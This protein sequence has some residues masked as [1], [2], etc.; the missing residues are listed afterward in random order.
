MNTI[1][2]TYWVALAVFA[3]A[4]N[5]EYQHGKFPLLH[6][7]AGRAG[8]ELCRIATRAEQT[9]AMARVLTG[10]EQQEFRVQ[11]FSMDEEFVARQEAEA[12]RAEHQADIERVMDLRRAD[13]DC[14]QQKLD[15]M[16]TALDRARLQKVRVLERTHLSMRDAANRRQIVVCPKTGARIAVD[17]SADLPDMDLEL[18]DVE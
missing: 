5:S 9:L 10:R 3:L 1:K 15:R 6:R 2:A 8:S 16:H 7:A 18:S 17:A 4:L 13:L 12:D 14:V 11:N